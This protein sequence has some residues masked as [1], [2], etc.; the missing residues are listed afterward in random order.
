[1]TGTA[2]IITSKRSLLS[3]LFDKIT[4]ALDR[5][6]EEKTKKNDTNINK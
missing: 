5:K 1:M 2:E 6:Y 4:S 3:K